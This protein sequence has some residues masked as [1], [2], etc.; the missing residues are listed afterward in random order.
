MTSAIDSICAESAGVRAVVRQIGERAKRVSARLDARYVEADA[1]AVPEHISPDDT[2]KVH[3]I[4][5]VRD[6]ISPPTA[7]AVRRI[8]R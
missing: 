7:R 4:E 8:S 6:A 1:G 3:H 5:D 2:S